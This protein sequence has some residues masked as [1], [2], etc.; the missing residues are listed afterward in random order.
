LASVGRICDGLWVP[1]HPRLEYQFSRDALWYFRVS[2]IP[3]NAVLYILLAPKL[4]PW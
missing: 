3:W 2:T 4:Y 1:H